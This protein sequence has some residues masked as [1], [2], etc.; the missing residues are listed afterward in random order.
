MVLSLHSRSRQ[1][2]LRSRAVVFVVVS[3]VSFV[4]CAAAGQ[5]AVSAAAGRAPAVYRVRIDT[6][7]GPFV[8][9]VHRDWAPHGADRFYELV[10]SHYYDDSRFYRTVAGKWVQFGI[11]GEPKV[12]TAWRSKTIPDDPPK[13]SN[14]KGTVAFAFAVPN[15]RTTQVYINL[16]DNS[17]QDS[18]GFAVFGKV[19]DGMA[20]VEALNTEYGEHSG[21]GI[22]AGKQDPLYAGGN[23][24]VD[25][26]YSRLDHLV[27]AVIVKP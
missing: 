11:A 5:G 18:Q 12:A 7:K 2:S 27:R 10:T 21:G 26:H 23:A 19:V 16:G 13:Q 8:V 1:T 14:V 22:R 25:A 9:E 15:G 6:T 4:V 24:Y 17:R 3:F 20:V